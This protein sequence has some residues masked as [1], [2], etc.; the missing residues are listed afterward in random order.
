MS[1]LYQSK[2]IDCSLAQRELSIWPSTTRGTQPLLTLSMVTSFIL[3]LHI[4]TCCGPDTDSDYFL[5]LESSHEILYYFDI[6][7]KD[8]SFPITWWLK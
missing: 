5:V 3:M 7:A 8:I 1:P 4:S 6:L 2:D